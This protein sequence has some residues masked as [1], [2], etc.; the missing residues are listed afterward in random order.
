MLHFLPA[1]LITAPHSARLG[2]NRLLLPASEIYKSTVRRKCSVRKTRFVCI[3][4]VLCRDQPPALYYC[5]SAGSMALHEDH[6]CVFQ[7][8]KIWS[9]L[10]SAALF[11][12]CPPGVH[13]A[14]PHVFYCNPSI[15]R[16]F[17]IQRMEQSGFP[18]PLNYQLQSQILEP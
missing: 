14:P 3:S 6:I 2:Q 8:E 7:C 16:Y 5:L 4:I 15:Y 13:S 11:S 9:A 12:G 18:P 17:Q 1:C 10:S